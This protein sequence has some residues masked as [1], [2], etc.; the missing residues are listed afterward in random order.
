MINP[1]DAVLGLCASIVTEIIK[2]VP[3]VRN[4]A[5]A[6]SI[7]AIIVVA[8][9]TFV[10][11]GV[12]TWPTFLNSLASAFLSYKIIVQPIARDVGMRTQATD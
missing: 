11:S 5:L 4:N 7:V 1:S 12:F 9:G 3:F 8:V 2:Y 6:S 10:S